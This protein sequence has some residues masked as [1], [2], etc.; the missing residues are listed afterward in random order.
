M[1]QF[2]I[3]RYE[4]TFGLVIESDLIPKERWVLVAPLIRNLPRAGA[5]NPVIP[6]AGIDHVLHIRSMAS[7]RRD[8]L[9]DTGENVIDSRDAVI[10]AVD[11]LICGI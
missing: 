2:D 3:V 9:E 10:R 5:L 8:A 11:F 6:V 4:S 7:V 1:K